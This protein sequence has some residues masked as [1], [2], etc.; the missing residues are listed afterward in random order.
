MKRFVWKEGGLASFKLKEDLYTIGQ[1]LKNPYFIF[2]KVSSEDGPFDG[3]DL[4]ETPVL[5]TI[6]VARDFM[7]QRAVEKIKEGVVPRDNPKL[8]TLWIQARNCFQCDYP[9]KGGDLV[10]IDPEVGNRGIMNP[11]VKRDI[12]P[13]DTETLEQYELTH[14]WTDKF[15]T[16]R[17]ILSL[18]RGENID[19][20]KEKIFFGTDA[21]GLFG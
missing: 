8:P 18:E 6:P 16:A 2:F 17:L 10:K 9:W 21:Y 12:D 5:F 13:D 14:I 7:Q 20:L 19:P 3:I 11:V 4:N 1:M 15:L